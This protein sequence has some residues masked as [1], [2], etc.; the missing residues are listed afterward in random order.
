MHR[1]TR[2]RRNNERGM[3]LLEIMIVLAIIGLIAAAIGTNVYRRFQ[4]ARIRTTKLQ[5]RQVVGH[6]QTAMLEDA[7]CQTI[8]QLVAKQ[9]LREIP[10]DAW[11]TPLVLHCPSEHE[12]DP[13]DVISFGPDKKENTEDDIASW[14]P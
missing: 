6:A 1:R 11:G 13:V 4:E 14:K 8:E 7:S 9:A 12:K 2:R 10:K 3:T 5:V